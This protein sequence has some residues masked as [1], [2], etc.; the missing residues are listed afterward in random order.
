MGRIF[1]FILV[2]ALL[3]VMVLAKTAGFIGWPVTIVLTVATALIGSAL[4][5]REGIQTWVRLQQ[6]MQHGELPGKEMAEGVMLLIGGALLITPGFITDIVGFCLLL[7]GSRGWMAQRLI[8]NGALQ[9]MATQPNVQFYY[10]QRQYGASTTHTTR[11]TTQ[12]PTGQHNGN[13][14]IDGS[15]ERLDRD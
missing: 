14:T 7:P 11:N 4:F 13:V 8:A 5:R 15:A 12:R 10:Q 6:R 2:F 9:R 3:E 1:L